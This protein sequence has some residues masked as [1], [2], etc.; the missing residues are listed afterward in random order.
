MQVV[1]G[2]FWLQYSQRL[3]ILQSNCDPACDVTCIS[4]NNPRWGITLDNSFLYFMSRC[5]KKELVDMWHS[6]HYFFEPA[7]PHKCLL[8][9]HGI[10]RF[11]YVV[12][13]IVQCVTFLIHMISKVQPINH[14]LNTFP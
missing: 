12:I 7:C 6:T 14:F 4:H 8:T 13:W 10:I 2:L 5:K 9:C 3:S 1:Q 11:R